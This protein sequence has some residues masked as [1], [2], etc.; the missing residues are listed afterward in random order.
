MGSILRARHTEKP[1]GAAGRNKVSE[2]S[3]DRPVSQ[4]RPVRQADKPRVGLRNELVNVEFGTNGP[5]ILNQ[6]AAAALLRILI[7][8][9]ER[10]A[11]AESTST[12][13]FEI[14]SDV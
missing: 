2:A 9:A 6:A 14:T 11:S 3:V 10:R 12:G 7:A 5:P 13:P 8:A 1:I 4:A